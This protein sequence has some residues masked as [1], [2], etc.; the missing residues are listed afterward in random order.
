MRQRYSMLVKK[1]SVLKWMSPMIQ[2]SDNAQVDVKRI[3]TI[4]HI[5]Q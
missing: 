2:A 1:T 3:Y 5:K 4:K